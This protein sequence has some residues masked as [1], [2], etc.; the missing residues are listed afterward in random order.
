VRQVIRRQGKPPENRVVSP[1][2]MDNVRYSTRPHL[3][4]SSSATSP[5][6]RSRLCADRLARWHLQLQKEVVRRIGLTD[7]ID[8]ST[9]L[10][11]LK[12]WCR[13]CLC[14]FGPR[15]GCLK[16]AERWQVSFDSSRSGLPDLRDHVVRD[17]LKTSRSLFVQ[18]A[19]ALRHAAC[20]RSEGR[21]FVPA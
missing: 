15:R 13:S 11:L 20:D 9:G 17:L 6:E 14:R 2:T 8:T 12:R 10:G 3:F 16:P 21:R 19:F 5:S 4:H 18:N 7:L 1:V